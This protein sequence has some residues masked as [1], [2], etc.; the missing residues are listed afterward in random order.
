[1]CASQNKP[2]LPEAAWERPRVRNPPFGNRSVGFPGVS[3]GQ[4]PL[5]FPGQAV[6]AAVQL[7][8][9]TEWRGWRDMVGWGRLGWLGFSCFL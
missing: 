2:Q 3:R 9:A 1:M 5:G 4:F 8:K 7:L 6:D